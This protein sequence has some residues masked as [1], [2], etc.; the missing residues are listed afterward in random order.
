[1]RDKPRSAH[2]LLLLTPLLL[3]AALCGSPREAR[4]QVASASV[5]TVAGFVVGTYT[6]TAIYVAKAR[7]GSYLFSLEEALSARFEILPVFAGPIA[8]GWLGA[9]SSTALERAALHGGVGF[10][11]GAA[12]GL[13]A[14]QLIWSDS[15]GRWAGAIIGSATG[16]LIGATLGALDGLDDPAAEPVPI[17]EIRI[18]FGGGR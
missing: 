4:A 2:P 9:R 12:A 7:F 17:L 15:D 18:P 1:M 14:G 6:M 13:L 5:G 10:V 11:G 3:V 16:L 8:G